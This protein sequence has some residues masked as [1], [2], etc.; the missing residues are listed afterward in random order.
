MTYDQLIE[1]LAAVGVKPGFG[2]R[3]VWKRFAEHLSEDSEIRAAGI[4]LQDGASS[5]VAIVVSPENVYIGRKANI[6]GGFD[7]STKKRSAITGADVSGT[8]TG[9]LVLTSTAGVVVG[10]HSMDKNQAR[11]IA[12]ELT[13]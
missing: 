11:K 10:A 8:L 2:N 1:K 12:A 7:I 9:K 3:G 5:P 13:E 4:G 6:L